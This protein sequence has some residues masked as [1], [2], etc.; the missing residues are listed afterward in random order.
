MSGA[1]VQKF[2]DAAENKIGTM[3]KQFKRTNYSIFSPPSSNSKASI[4]IKTIT[5]VITNDANLSIK[6]QWRSQTVVVNLV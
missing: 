2:P 3:F 6:D 4:Y 1:I 5:M